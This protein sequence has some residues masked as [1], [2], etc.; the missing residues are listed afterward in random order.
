MSKIV[1]FL[2]PTCIRR[3]H[4][5]SRRNIAIKFDVE[6]LEWYGYPMVKI[7]RRY[8]YSFGQNTRTWRTDRQTLRDSVGRTYKQHCAPK[9]TVQHCL[10]RWLYWVTTWVY[11]DMEHWRATTFSSN[12]VWSSTTSWSAGS[13]QVCLI[14]EFPVINSVYH[15]HLGTI[16][17]RKFR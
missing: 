3:P 5:G 9:K 13:L 16:T 7:I 10:C 8:V 14:A 2:Y 1:I 4:K 15:S 11:D 17:I 12:G 6:K